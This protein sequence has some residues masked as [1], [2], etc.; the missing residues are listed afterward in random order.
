MILISGPPRSGKTTLARKIGS[1]NER[2]HLDQ[3]II[4]IGIKHPELL[5]NSINPDEDIDLTANLSIKIQ[6]FTHHLK[7]I[8]Q[9]ELI[10]K[11]LCEL[12]L[13]RKKTKVIEGESLPLITSLLFNAFKQIHFTSIVLNSDRN[14]L[15]LVGTKLI[16]YNKIIKYIHFRT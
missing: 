5:P 12:M 7:M 2:I 1:C 6:E 13:L 16:P 14:G 11:E 3:I 9:Q 10:F 8:N 4:M 15:S